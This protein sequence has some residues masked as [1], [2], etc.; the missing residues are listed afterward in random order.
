MCIVTLPLVYA[1]TWSETRVAA[2]TL[3]KSG[4]DIVVR[5]AIGIGHPD[6]MEL[7]GVRERQ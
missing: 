1:S 2:R 4:A 5:I 7:I 3:M 6:A